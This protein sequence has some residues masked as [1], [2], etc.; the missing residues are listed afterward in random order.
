MSGNMG[1][2]FDNCTC[3]PAGFRIPA[4]MISDFQTFLHYS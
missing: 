4:Y 2:Y 3:H 1:M